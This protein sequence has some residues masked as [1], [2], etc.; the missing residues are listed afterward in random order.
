MNNAPE[1]RVQYLVNYDL[2]YNS[3]VPSSRLN[4]LSDITNINNEDA[5]IVG[6][7]GLILSG[8]KVDSE[9]GEVSGALLDG[10]YT[11]FKDNEKSYNGIMG[12]VLSGD[13]YTF[14][15]TSEMREERKK[16][17]YGM[18]SLPSYVRK[19]FVNDSGLEECKKI[20]GIHSD[21]IIK[22]LGYKNYDAVITRDN[23]TDL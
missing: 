20:I 13:D 15:E 21:S 8:G 18:K 6:K 9:T 22:I 1:I 12:N 4:P 3:I 17:G 10:T 11:F 5:R 16:L 7:K 14:I 2:E 23:I 19:S